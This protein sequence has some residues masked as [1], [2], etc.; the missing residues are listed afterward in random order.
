MKFCLH[1]QTQGVSESDRAISCQRIELGRIKDD[2]LN[3]Q[4]E[5]ECYVSER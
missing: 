1:N 4:P 5:L 3:R 2:R